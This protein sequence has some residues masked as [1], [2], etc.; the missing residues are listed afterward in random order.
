MTKKRDKKR[1]K[2]R[3]LILDRDDP[4]RELDFEIDY[5]LSLTAEERYEIMNQLVND[6]MELI[7]Q[8]GYKN[9]PLFVTRA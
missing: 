4:V 8:H 9:T 7:K 6:G 1:H 3:I 5:Q 2:T